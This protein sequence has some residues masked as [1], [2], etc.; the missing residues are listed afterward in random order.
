MIQIEASLVKAEKALDLSNE[1]F[2]NYHCDI[3]GNIFLYLKHFITVNEIT[4]NNVLG[5]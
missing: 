5:E 3:I 1:L 4:C 2:I